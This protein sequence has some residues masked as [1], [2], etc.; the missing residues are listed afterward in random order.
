[1]SLRIDPA[2]RANYA[3]ISYEEALPYAKLFTY[4]STRSFGDKLTYAAY[5]Y[6]PVSFIFCERDG[7]LPP[8]YQKRTIARIE[9]ASGREVQVLGIDAG[10]CPATTR[11]EEF[12]GLVRKAINQD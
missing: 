11:P 8:A 3:D 1:M 9:E 12:A 6:V 2:I 4:H 7:T 10:H 5:K